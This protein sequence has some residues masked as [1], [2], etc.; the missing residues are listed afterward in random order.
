MGVFDRQGGQLAMPTHRGVSDRHSRRAGHET[1]LSKTKH[2]NLKEMMSDWRHNRFKDQ[3]KVFDPQL[4]R[5]RNPAAGWAM[6]LSTAGDP[7]KSKSSKDS[8]NESYST[9]ESRFAKDNVGNP[10]AGFTGLSAETVNSVSQMYKAN[11][12]RAKGEV[13]RAKR[14]I[15]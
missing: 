6:T 14:G 10:R 9:I 4:R 3:Y 15:F 11:S 13:R 5:N 8:L 12:D 1:G 2:Y 7:K